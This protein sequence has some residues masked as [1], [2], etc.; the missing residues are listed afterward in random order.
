M[1]KTK[2]RKTVSA[3]K[4]RRQR[5]QR[6]LLFCVLLLILLLIGLVFAIA[7]IAPLGFSKISEAV[8]RS[9]KAAEITEEIPGT[10]VMVLDKSGSLTVKSVEEFSTELYSEAEL[11]SELNLETSSMPGV[12]VESFAVEEGMA[13]LTVRYASDADYEAFNGIPF[14]Y[15]AAGEADAR[16]YSLLSLM[17][18]PSVS[19]KDKVM[20]GEELQKMKDKLVVVLTQEA[21][22]TLPYKI[23]YAAGDVTITG[24]KTASI[25]SGVSEDTPAILLIDGKKK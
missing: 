4:R 12:T 5:E 13:R 1:A 14:Y 16:G 3:R 19:K 17:G 21:D 18:A 6:L 9:P 7:K 8:E 25:G 11:L 2:K 15:G 23:L 24:A 10:D 20:N 22:V